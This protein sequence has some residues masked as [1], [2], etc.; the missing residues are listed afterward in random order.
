MAF[1]I[2]TPSVAYGGEQQTHEQLANKLSEQRRAEQIQ[3]ALRQRANQPSMIRTIDPPSEQELARQRN[4]RLKRQGNDASSF[5]SQIAAIGEERTSIRIA[6]DSAH[7][8]ADEA[9]REGRN[10]DVKKLRARI[11]DLNIEI[12]RMD[13]LEEEARVGLAHAEREA[14]ARLVA[15]EASV[16]EAEA[17]FKAFVTVQAEY[18]RLAAR[19]VEIIA[20][21]AP[22]EV[23]YATLR[24][25]AQLIE[26]RELPAPFPTQPGGRALRVSVTLP[27]HYNP[28]AKPPSPNDAY[29]SS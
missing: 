23:A 5:R 29:A 13:L 22:A 16:P 11:E 15:L 21:E 8:S 2:P 28:P 1:P 9:L 18:T 7:R 20:L 24:Q 26:G 14:G 27:G 3:H 6:L 17:R 10:H 19:I 4:E 12:D 25:A